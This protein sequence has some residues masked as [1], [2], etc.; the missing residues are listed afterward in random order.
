MERQE[1]CVLEGCAA[2]LVTYCSNT[3]TCDA[4]ALYYNGYASYSHQPAAVY[5][6]RGND[7]Q[8]DLGAHLTMSPQAVLYVKKSSWTGNGGVNYTEVRRHAA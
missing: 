1:C 8:L 4:L 7:T 3:S 5:K 6:T 2:D